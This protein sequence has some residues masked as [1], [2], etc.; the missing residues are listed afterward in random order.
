MGTLHTRC[1]YPGLD[2]VPF[3]VKHPQTG[4]RIVDFRIPGEKLGQD[5]IQGLSQENP[6]IFNTSYN[7]NVSKVYIFFSFHIHSKVAS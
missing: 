7:L 6:D 3:P 5:V 4:H 2:H 1:C